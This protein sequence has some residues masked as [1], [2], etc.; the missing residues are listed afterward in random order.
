M[1]ARPSIDDLIKRLNSARESDLRS[2]PKLTKRELVWLCRKV[3]RIFK[4]QPVFLELTSPITICGDLHGQF[5]DLVKIFDPPMTPDL[6][7]YLFLGDYVDRGPF[8]LDTISL[9]FAYKVKYLNNFFLLK[10]NHECPT[11]NSQYGFLDECA[12]AFPDSPIWAKFNDCFAWMPIAAR[13]D[14]RIFCV[15]GGIARGLR[16]VDQLK[17]ILRPDEGDTR[18]V[19]DL[20]WSDPD[21]RI[22]NWAPNARGSGWAF[23]P[24]AA[25][26]FLRR[27]GLDLVVRAH[28]SVPGGYEFPYG[29][30][31]PV[32]TVF[33]ASRYCGVHPN[34]G[35]VLHVERDLRLSFSTFDATGPLAAAG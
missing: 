20:L 22:D 8:S 19:C 7:D 12:H 17:T 21:P 32:V 25:D 18:L 3:K 35:A 10:G 28:E 29:P 9:L 27:N 30:E 13:I 5:S 23:G 2:R 31:T 26:R 1:R 34:K 6:T 4:K 33:S 16:D 15:H 11:V 24:M 14:G